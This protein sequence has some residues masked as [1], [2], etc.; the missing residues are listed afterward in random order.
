MLSRLREGSLLMVAKCNY[1]KKNWLEQ[2][3]IVA[4]LLHWL[5]ESSSHQAY[6]TI[7]LLT[8]DDHFGQ[9]F[10]HGQIWAT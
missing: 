2:K 6:D 10:Y 4:Y 9:W 3:E 7:P 8:F 5:I 1:G